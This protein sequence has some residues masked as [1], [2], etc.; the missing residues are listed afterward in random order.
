[1]SLLEI[2][3]WSLVA[4]V[5]Y[6]YVGYP[7]LLGLLARVRPR[8]VNRGTNGP[9]S[10]SIV[11]CVRNE[12]ANIDRRLAELTDLLESTGVR[13]EII[14]VS[15]G[16]TDAT[17]T[18]AR[19]HCKGSVRVLELPDNVG[20]AAALSS[21]CAMAMN[22]ILVFADARQRWATDAL[23][24]LLENFADPEVG[25]ATGGLVI[26]S[27]P[28]TLAGVGLYWRFEKWLR[29][30]ES[31]VWSMVGATGA[32]SAV[33]RELFRPIPPGTVLDDVYWPLQVVLQGKRV[34]LDPRA[35]AH[36]R[37]PDRVRDE[38]R[39][40]VRTLSGN[41][42]LLARLPQVLLPWRCPIWFS[43][44]SHKALRLVVPWAL[45]VIL[46]LSAAMPSTLYQILF[47]GQIA[48]YATG[49]AGALWPALARCSP[50][51]GASSFV[52]LNAAAALA[53]WV[54]LF[55]R[56]TQSWS[57]VHYKRLPNASAREPAKVIAS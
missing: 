55:G 32:I 2:L 40:K 4:L 10:C 26:E 20:K 22:E 14:V 54:W 34:V 21:G 46:V 15:D 44:L 30:Q 28:G 11:L 36:D 13:G 23:A 8:P 38:F 16:S 50:V 31:R 53:F 17:A 1:M 6:A 37:L 52:V 9:R 49:V 39:R 48:G 41:F 24:M 43:V 3:F 56:T 51:S 33:R 5:A 7:L 18:L 12:E 42:Q 47:W 19:Q 29:H 27:A 57:P 35:V 25:A 45:M